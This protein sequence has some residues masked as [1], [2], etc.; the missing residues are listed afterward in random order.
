M[1]L[2]QL[3]AFI[4]IAELQSFSAAAKMTGLSQPSLSRQLKQLE[5][6]MEVVLIDRYHRPLQLT[7]AG[8]FF[9]D[10]VSTVLTELNNITSM[11]QRLAAPSTALNIGFVPSIL[12]GHLPDI[13]ANLKR[14][15]PDIAVNLK[16]ISSYQQIEALKSG[17][18][19]I[20]FGRFAHQDAW[21]QQILL[22]F[23]FQNL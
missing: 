23:C 16:D 17:E 9:Y 21:V 6:D 7:E 22:M 14:Q 20:G 19:D 3:N 13:I 1:D 10:K 12:Y 8:Q 5:T 15:N 18:I 11:T 2:K 4:A